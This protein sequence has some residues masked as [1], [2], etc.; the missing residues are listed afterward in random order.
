MGGDW[1]ALRATLFGDLFTSEA[2]LALV[3]PR[4][5]VA[6]LGCGTGFATELLA[7]V[8]G[9]VIAVDREP[10]MLDAARQRLGDVA[11]VEFRKGDLT[12]LPLADGEVE[13]AVC[14]LVMVYLDDPAGA[15]AEMARILEPGGR[16]VIVDM[17]RHDRSSYLHTMGQK[18]LGF[19]CS[20][21]QA[22]ASAAGFAEVRHR[23]LR[24]D[25]SAKGP[26]LF[27]AVLGR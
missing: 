3:S 4:L 1:D 27:A 10:A 15:V 13:A 26:G 7:P 17:V 25:T 8:V 2:L 23:L 22:W 16:A 5:L 6:D 18:H 12:A 21:V 9:A 14:L 19:A 11:N 20:D 24:P